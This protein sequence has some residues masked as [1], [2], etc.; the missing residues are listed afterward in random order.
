[1]LSA[2]RLESARDAAAPAACLATALWMKPPPEHA[3][4]PDGAS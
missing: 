4:L 2:D 1:M 3:R